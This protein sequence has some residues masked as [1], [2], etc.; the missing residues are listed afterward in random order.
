MV[1]HANKKCSAALSALDIAYQ[2]DPANPQ[3]RYQ[4]AA[5]LMSLDRWEEALEELMN[6]R[7]HAPR[8]AAVHYLIGKVF[9]KLGDTEGAMRAFVTALDLDP[10]D[11]NLIKAAID[12]LDEPDVEDDVSGF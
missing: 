6:V 7:D 2:L 3:A 8:E 11:N 12:R 4:R 10:K 1:L 5:V 9:K